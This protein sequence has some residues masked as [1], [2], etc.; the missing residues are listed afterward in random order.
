ML[1]AVWDG[2][3][4]GFGLGSRA[5]SALRRCPPA[6]NYFFKI[7]CVSLAALQATATFHAAGFVTSG[8]ATVAYR[9]QNRQL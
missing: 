3:G 1:R 8:G 9:Q 6:G 7:A 2:A 5:F 4:I